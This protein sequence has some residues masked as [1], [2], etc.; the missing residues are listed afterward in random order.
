M[1]L[2]FKPVKMTI[3]GQKVGPF[4]VPEGLPMLDCLHEIVGL[5]G[6]RR[7]CGIGECRACVV[8]H[9]RPDGT[10]EEVRTCITPAHYF[11]GKQIRTVEGHATRNAAGEIVALSPVQQKFLEHY[12]FQCGYCTPGFVN[13]ATVLIERLRREP[14]AKSQVE[15]VITEALD[16]HLCRCTGYVRYYAALKDLILSTPD[17]TRGA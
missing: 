4:D 2:V 17:L 16:T 15:S 9:D 14:V 6:S 7:G 12:S 13:G 11:D 5:T 1:T 10:S 3:N 8:I